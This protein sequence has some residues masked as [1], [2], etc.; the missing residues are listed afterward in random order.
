VALD[1]KAQDDHPFWVL[2]ISDGSLN[3]ESFGRL[4]SNGLS[5]FRERMSKAWIGL[6]V[7]LTGVN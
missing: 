3:H 4:S 6:A 7:S 5:G 2:S 1:F